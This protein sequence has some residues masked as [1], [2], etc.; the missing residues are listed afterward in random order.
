TGDGLGGASSDVVSVSTSNSQ[1]SGAVTVNSS[2]QLNM[3]TLTATL[4]GLLLDGGNVA[5]TGTVTL[6]ANIQTLASSQVATI[7]TPIALNGNRVF[8]VALSGNANDLTFTGVISGGNQVAKIGGGTLTPNGSA[9][10]TSTGTTTVAEGTLVLAMTAGNAMTG[11][12]VV[13]D[14]SGTD[15]VRVATGTN[16]NQFPTAEPVIVNASGTFD[17]S[18]STAA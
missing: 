10:N 14:F 5:G 16:V 11:G 6:G 2:G 9:A 3:S 12:L 18:G 15:T 1:I 17:T 7:A 4:A 8:N 13:G